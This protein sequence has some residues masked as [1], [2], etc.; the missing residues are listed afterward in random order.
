VMV[1]GGI[2]RT[3]FGL[4][5]LSSTPGSLYIFEDWVKIAYYAKNCQLKKLRRETIPFKLFGDG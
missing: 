5:A 4:T 2:K 1:R 3:V